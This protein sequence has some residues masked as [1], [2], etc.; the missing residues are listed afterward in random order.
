MVIQHQSYDAFEQW[1]K[2]LLRQKRIPLTGMMEL[3]PRCN[4]RCAHC[5]MGQLR[6]DSPQMDTAFIQSLLPQ[7][8]QAGCL[9]LSFTGG[10]PL[11]RRDYKEIHAT[12]HRLGFWI[13]LMTNGALVDARLIQFLKSHPPRAVEVSLYGGNEQS[14]Q[15]LTGVAGA[16]AKVTQNV[17]A[18]LD[19][20][21]NVILKSVLL[22]PIWESIDEMKAFA[23]ERHLEMLFDAG[24][25]PDLMADFSP[26][27]LR[28]APGCA[29]A[30]ELD[31]EKKKR[32]LG[33]YHHKHMEN[34]GTPLGFACDAG[35][36]GFHIDY[37]GNLLACLMLR[38]PAFSLTE[39][40]FADAWQLLGQ[41]AP[42]RFPPNARCNHCELLHLCGFCPGAVSSGEALP[43]TEDFFYCKVARARRRILE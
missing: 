40:S 2:S 28:L 12:A 35:R 30:I 5:Y 13:N 29:V 7:I 31:S 22:R 23:A 15:A 33:D 25:T 8:A 4:F 14:Y 11:L 10:E 37:R 32:L 3:T 17:D 19:A 38:E 24:V 26:T 18:M 34:Q 21:L 36:R 27:E 9:A 6:D 43:E 41:S 20:G 39:Y 42:P 1:L 16:F